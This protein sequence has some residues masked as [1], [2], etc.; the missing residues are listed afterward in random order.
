MAFA[1]IQS[2]RDL[3]VVV[4][5][6]EDNEGWMLTGHLHRIGCQAR[7]IWPIPEALPSDADVVV[8]SIQH[9]HRHDIER[10]IKAMGSTPPT[11][12]AV[13][14]YENPASLQVV[15]QCGAHAVLERPVKPFGVLTNLAIAR[16]LWAE[17]RALRK[18]V[19]NYRRRAL[20]DQTVARAKAILMASGIASEDDAYQQLRQAS[21][22]ER[23][24]IETV[25]KRIV[26]ANE[27]EAERQKRKP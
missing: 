27:L 6:P 5:H 20:G 12:L 13:V 17:Q 26:D 2:L 10:V 19:R 4:L 25:A 3:S 8:I 15:L 14:E 1:T 22:L 18:E 11:I 7:L 9:E 16:H 24:S 23:V 21:Q